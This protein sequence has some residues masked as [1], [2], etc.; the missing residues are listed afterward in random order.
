MWN[1]Q[2]II[3]FLIR[4]GTTGVHLQNTGV[5]VQ[6]VGIVNE[7]NHLQVSHS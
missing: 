1:F 4:Y 6:A 5:G 7:R 2:K 3:S